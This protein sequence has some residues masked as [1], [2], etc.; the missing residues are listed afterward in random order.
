MERLR[1]EAEALGREKE[2]A[3]E[4]RKGIQRELQQQEGTVKEL[5][6]E[7]ERER[8]RTRGR[9]SGRRQ[10]DWDDDFDQSGG[11]D[12]RQ[13]PP[14]K[15]RTKAVE[16]PP[17][18]PELSQAM[19]EAAIQKQVAAAFE[20]VLPPPPREPGPGAYSSAPP[21]YPGPVYG[22]Y[23][24]QGPGGVQQVS[25]A[26]SWRVSSPSPPHH[27]STWAYGEGHRQALGGGDLPPVPSSNPATGRLQSAGRPSSPRADHGGQDSGKRSRSPEAS[28]AASVALPEGN[29]EMMK[30]F[31]EFM[32]KHS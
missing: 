10:K 8:H 14:K 27:P 24:Y 20:R 6:R 23:H 29:A 5:E 22:G 3:V 18:A 2:Q 28:S 12:V 26:P 7:L 13:A 11:E 16:P 4:A 1:K 17:A 9:G 15:A 19:I 30:A 21:V 32:K 25:S 31:L